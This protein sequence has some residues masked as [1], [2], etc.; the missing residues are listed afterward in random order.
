MAKKAPLRVFGCRWLPSDDR[1]RIDISNDSEIIRSL[2]DG[3]CEIILNPE[4]LRDRI[5]DALKFFISARVDPID[6]KNFRQDISQLIEALDQICSRF[7]VDCSALDDSIKFCLDRDED[8]FRDAYKTFADEIDGPIMCDSDVFM[9]RMRKGLALVRMVVEEIVIEESGQIL[10]GKVKWQRG[11]D[12]DRAHEDFM[13][14]LA[15]IWQDYTGKAPG[16]GAELSTSKGYR[17]PFERFVDAVTADIPPEIR[18]TLG[19]TRYRNRDMKEHPIASGKTLKRHP[20]PPKA[21]PE[22]N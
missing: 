16:Q 6:L 15:C 10:E 18:P 14:E 5:L 11:I 17:S 20:I 13:N 19:A 3:E 9:E 7:P 12:K 22:E 1:I 4:A 8:R 21:E 2:R